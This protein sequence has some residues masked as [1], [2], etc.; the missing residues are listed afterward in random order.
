MSIP[1]FMKAA[2]LVKQDS[3][4][5]IDEVELP[6]NLQVGQVLV[7]VNVSGICGSQ[8]GEIDG[9]KGKDNYLPHLMGHEGCGKVIEIGPGVKTV[10]VGEKVVLHWRKGAGIQSDTPTYKWRQKKLNAGWVTTFNEYAIVSENRCTSIPTDVSDDDAALFGC[11]VTTGFGVV[12]NNAKLR[13]GESVM[14]FG[15]GGIGLNIIQASKLISAWPIIA[16]DIFDNRLELA[17]KFGATHTINSKKENVEKKLYQIIG[18]K[19][20]DVFIDNT[21]IPRIIEKGYELTNSKGRVVLV[22]VPPKN[23]NIGIYSLPLHFGKIILGSHGGES[24]P[25]L[26]IPR[27]MKLLRNKKISFDGLVTR[28]YVL[29]DINSAINA[30][31]IGSSA[32]RILIDL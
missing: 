31:R 30:M 12:E 26:D 27:Y 24:V 28:R 23:S 9:K 17:K 29:D 32:G 15:A 18:E 22:G 4:L 20:L 1:E 3:E 6:K 14:I 19:S 8:L 2:I 11:A 16:V 21:G 13:L 5:I 10:S 7:K 25:E